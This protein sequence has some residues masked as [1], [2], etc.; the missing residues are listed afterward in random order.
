MAEEESPDE[1][2]PSEEP[3]PLDEHGADDE[4]GAIVEPERAPSPPRPVLAGR[5]RYR[6]WH[7]LSGALALG[8][9]L[10][11]HLL[12]NASV[13][14]GQ[15]SYDA[16]VGSIE[17]W[18]L[19]PIFEVLFI[20]VPLAF[21]AGYG[22]LLLRRG[23][24]PDSEVARYGDRRLWVLQRVTAGLVLAFVLGHFVELRLQRL[25]FGL[26][27]DGLH[28]T[29]AA[30]LS[31]TWAGVPWFALLYLLGLLATAFHFSNGLYAAT[32]AW[33]LAPGPGGRR[34]MR[35][36]LNA[37]GGL[38]FLVG[39]ASVVALAT[40]GKLYPAA[41]LA[42]PCGAAMTPPAPSPSR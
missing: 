3:S 18:R 11:E 5:E 20:L 32:A 22:A 38:A 34:R 33:G 29:L 39:A 40:G 25:F 28:S 24:A 35:M 13:L 21:H 14:G 26:A 17:R 36:G 10:I 30:D 41:E 31:W 8:A 15:A 9:F 4:H 6:R 23:S 16:V 2:S 7:T 12:T 19:L 27:A 37:L 42:L 1:R